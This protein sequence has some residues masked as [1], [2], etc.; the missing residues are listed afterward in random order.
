M[1]KIST[2]QERIK[3]INEIIKE[4]ASHDRQFLSNHSDGHF[5]GDPKKVSYFFIKDKILYLKDH[6]RT[7]GK[8]VNM[9]KKHYRNPLCHGGTLWG[10]IMDFTNFIKTGKYSNHMHGY[11]GL[12]CPHWGYKPESM[13][14]IREKARELGYLAKTDDEDA[15]LSRKAMN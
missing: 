15:N 13:I 2:K 9:S 14:K 3:I 12:Y 4:I 5:N 1:I 7:D 11:G 6:Y 8:L 10:L